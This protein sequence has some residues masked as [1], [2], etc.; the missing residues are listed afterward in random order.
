[1]K[2]ILVPLFLGIAG[3]CAAQQPTLSDGVKALVKAGEPII[4]LQHV[5][6]IDGTGAPAADDQTIIIEAG[7]IRWVGAAA[8][9][10]L[11][12]GAR[13]IDLA[14]HS[15]L[16]GLVGMHDHMFYP[17]GGGVYHEMAFSFPRLYLAAG[18]TTLRTTGS[19]E[20]YTDLELKKS[21]DGGE[22]PGPHLH[23]TGPYLEGD[24]APILQLHALKSPQEARDT[25]AFW[26]N[27]GVDSFKAY[28]FLTRAELGAAIEEAHKRNIKVTGHLCSIGFHEAVALGIDNL[29]HGLIVDTE[30]FSQK[31]PDVCP[32]SDQVEVEL[33]R[34]PVDDPRLQQLIADLVSHHVAV[35]STL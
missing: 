15:V 6:V 23:I 4:A 3:S 25:V 22:S 34:I 26:A 32:S 30:F 8:A 1:M 14:G 18:V 21:I 10:K 5:R 33:A 2:R 9:A 28:N 31:K 13:A 35:T 29:E 11:P 27:Q 20:P 7:R 16:P 17:A 19:I 12:Y 24:P